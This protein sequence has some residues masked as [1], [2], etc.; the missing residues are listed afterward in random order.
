M[1]GVR[2]AVIDIGSN[3]IRLVV[4]AGA[5]R[6]PMPIYNEKSRVSLGT[7]LA[8][9]G[10]IDP[11][12][13]DRALA[14]IGRFHTLARAM[15]VDALRV[16]ATAATREAKNG[17]ELV[18]RADDMGIR[19]EVIDGL[20]EAYLAGLGIISEHP[21]ANG[22]AGDLGGGSLELAR[23]SDGEIGARV[24]L[25]FGTLRLDAMKGV[26]AKEFAVQIKEA[27][28]QASGDSDFPIDKNLPFFMVGGS[29]RA[30]ARLQIYSSAFP[31]SVLANYVMPPEAPAELLELS[32]DRE[33]LATHKV[34]PSGRI[35]ALPGATAL[36]S[37][38]VRLFKPSTLVTSI[39]GL[40][41]GLL[42]DRLSLEERRRDPFVEAARHEGSRLARFRF[43]GDALAD[44]IAPVFEDEGKQFDRLRRIAC[45]LAD[46]AWN[47]TPEY[48]G[49]VAVSLALDGN[50]PGATTE[51]RAIL[52][53]ALLAVH[54]NKRS[55]DDLLQRLAPAERLA[56]GTSWGQAIRLA[57]RLDGGTGSALS[58]TRLARK[59]DRLELHLSRLSRR[60]RSGSV[61][62]R[63]NQLAQ[64]VGLSEG[65]VVEDP[66]PT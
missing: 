7:C 54:N 48:R 15:D 8:K 63:L 17:A 32:E 39:S 29:W 57:H 11:E 30:L 66:K 59:G 51:D 22:Y 42:F 16:V 58:D 19:I 34:V 20:T 12:T 26:G 28:D 43:H 6:A 2:Q 38:V 47:V 24:S 4:Y 5:L 44:W 27:L 56:K 14:A 13:M 21:N 62:R 3:S 36:L 45:L 60:L 53:A 25:P 64:L 23:I 55:L 65:R 61:E 49:D 52:A 37:G 1:S 10:V 46:T 33:M 9:D 40:R 31:L 41:E 18:S 35:D 50:W